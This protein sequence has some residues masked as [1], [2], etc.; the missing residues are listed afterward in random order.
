MQEGHGVTSPDKT[1]S[2]THVDRLTL[3]NIAHDIFIPTTDYFEEE[4]HNLEVLPNVLLWCC[5]IRLSMS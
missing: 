1:H 3:E 4:K 5:H 2:C